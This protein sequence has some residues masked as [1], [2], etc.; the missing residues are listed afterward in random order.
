MPKTLV[1]ARSARDCLSS[2]LRGVH[3]TKQSSKNA[4]GLLQKGE[5]WIASLSFAMTKGARD[6]EVIATPAR[7]V[8]A[9]SLPRHCEEHKRRSNPARTCK[10]YFKKG[11]AGLLLRHCEEH[12]DAAIAMTKGVAAYWRKPFLAVKQ[13]LL[14]RPIPFWSKTGAMKI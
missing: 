11:D 5:R 14:R 4:Q 2:S 3:A 13:H 7:A 1:M 6:E 12:S 8:N 9:T 10:G